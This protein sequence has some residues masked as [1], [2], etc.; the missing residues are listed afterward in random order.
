QKMDSK[1]NWKAYDLAEWTLD[2]MIGHY[3]ELIFNE[4]NRELPDLE[5]I[6][7]W[8][9]E[10]DKLDEERDS[11]RVDEASNSIRIIEAYGPTTKEFMKKDH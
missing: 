6:Q 3:S 10:Q 11:L 7:T 5:K 4:Q 9:N 2:L 8:R 1:E